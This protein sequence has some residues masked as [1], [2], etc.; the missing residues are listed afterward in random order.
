MNVFARNLGIPRD[1]LGATD[2]ILQGA[3]TRLARG[4]NLGGLND[5]LFTFACG[6]GFDAEAAGRVEERHASK[7]RF[8]EPYFYTTALMTFLRSYAGR[9]PFLDCKATFG[10]EEAVMLAACTSGPYAYLFGRPVRLGSGSQN[11]LD[12]FILR[13]L[14]YLHL[15]RYAIGA[16]FGGG[17]GPE[18]RMEPEVETVDVSGETAF[19]VHAD[20]EPLAPV[21]HARISSRAARVEVLV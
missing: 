11:G 9:A 3:G 21:N 14:R 5:R 2:R 17:F 1:P 8:G 10:R 7:R 19:A 15:P 16:A 6:C 18:A 13:R 20:G 4:V 12:V